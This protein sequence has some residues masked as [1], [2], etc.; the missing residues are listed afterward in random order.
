MNQ[1][2]ANLMGNIYF[3]WE[4]MAK[5]NEKTIIW[6]ILQGTKKIINPLIYSSMIG[7]PFFKSHPVEVHPRCADA[8]KCLGLTWVSDNTLK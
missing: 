8:H 2:F 3:K 1:K 6:D 5:N 7:G 4:A